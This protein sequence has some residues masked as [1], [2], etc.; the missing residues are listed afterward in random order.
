MALQKV[1]L[2]GNRR[3]VV[4]PDGAPGPM[5]I[6]GPPGSR[7]AMGPQGP[8]GP[9]GPH[10][11]RG[12]AGVSGFEVVTARMPANGFNSE[13]PKQVTAQCPTGKRVIG[14]GATIEGTNGDL[15]GLVALQEIAPVRG[16]A[17]G[18][19]V[20]VGSTDVRWALVAFAFCAAEPS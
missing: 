2:K 6:P 15:D 8:E 19:A 3:R 10:G 20:E 1:R 18:R 17:R 16:D 11:E 14:T 9:P 12:P 4:G 13:S 5:G 7:G